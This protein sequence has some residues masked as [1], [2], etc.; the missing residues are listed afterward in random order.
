[1][2]TVSDSTEENPT[3]KKKQ[4]G[5]IS[6]TFVDKEKAAKFYT[7]ESNRYCYLIVSEL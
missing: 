1:M 5:D 2:T 6:A 4:P 3:E 7:E